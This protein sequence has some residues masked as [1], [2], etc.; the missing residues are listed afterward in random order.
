LVV[1]F[2]YLG[3]ASWTSLR[4]YLLPG[5]LNASVPLAQITSYGPGR[6]LLLSKLLLLSE[7]EEVVVVE[8]LQQS[9]LPMLTRGVKVLIIV[10]LER[11]IIVSYQVV[12]LLFVSDVMNCFCT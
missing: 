9:L 12:W 10:I 3:I 8:T 5:A 7:V 2:A 1:A 11:V 6:K 4:K